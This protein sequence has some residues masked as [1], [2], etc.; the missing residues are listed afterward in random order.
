ML[1]GM[2][3]Q[4]QEQDIST[5]AAQMHGYVGADLAAVCT[6]AGFLALKRHIACK[7]QHPAAAAHQASVLQVR[8]PGRLNIMEDCRAADLS[9]AAVLQATSKHV[10]KRMQPRPEYI[11]FCYPLQVAGAP[12]YQQHECTQVQPVT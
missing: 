7:H 9:P 8:P 2:R 6:R 5:L 1:G 4:L 12:R 11:D 10:C 3:H